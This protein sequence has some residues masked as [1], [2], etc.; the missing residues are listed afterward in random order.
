MNL[1]IEITYFGTESLP[2]GSCQHFCFTHAV[3]CVNIGMQINAAI[4]LNR[5]EQSCCI[6]D[7]RMKID[8]GLNLLVKDRS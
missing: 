1:K 5:D 7:G 6:C 2:N 4:I 8:H 3:Q